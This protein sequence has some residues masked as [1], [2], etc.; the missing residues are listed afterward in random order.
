M[1][2]QKK[3]GDEAMYFHDLRDISHETE[4]RQTARRK[5]RLRGR[6]SVHADGRCSTLLVA[7]YTKPIDK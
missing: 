6:G 5:Q 4:P 2:Q 3:G 7:I 1:M